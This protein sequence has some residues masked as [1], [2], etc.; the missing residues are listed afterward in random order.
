[1]IRAVVFDVDGTLVDSVDLHAAC[2][3]EAFLKF[4]TEVPFDQV[5]WQIGKGGDQLMPVFL[6]PELI[7]ERGQDIESYR[8]ARFREFYLPKVRPFPR[9]AE[10][11]KRLRDDEKLIA[12]AS[13]AQG[14]ELEA[15]KEMADIENLIDVE[16]TK[17][18]AARSKPCPDIFEAALEQLDIKNVEAIVVGDAPYDAMAAA[19]A[20]LRSIGVLS[21]GFPKETLRAAGCFAL[22]EDAADLLHNYPSSAIA[23]R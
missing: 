9:V 4:G 8:A 7:R 1:M 14:P 12:L 16:V 15:Y 11:F 17:D 19:R 18:D 10:L 20:G 23:L 13:S 2:W 6:S 3:Q 21:G 22:Y 5:R